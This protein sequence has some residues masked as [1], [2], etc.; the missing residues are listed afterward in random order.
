LPS[1]S[2]NNFVEH[3]A[4]AENGQLIGLTSIEVFT[5]SHLRLNR[6]QLVTYR[7]NRRRQI[8]SKQLLQQYQEVIAS[9]EQLNDQL[10]G[11]VTGQKKLLLQQQILIRILMQ[12]RRL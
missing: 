11:L 5:I 6:S 12:K 8:E 9:L 1:C 10:S 4:E 2:K 7:Q 3:F